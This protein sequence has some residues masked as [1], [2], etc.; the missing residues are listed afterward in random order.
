MSS[1]IARKRKTR[2]DDGIAGV[3]GDGAGG[4]VKTQDMM[5]EIMALI[6]Q[7]NLQLKAQMQN[8]MDTMRRLHER[9]IDEMKRHYE[10]EMN[11]IKEK[12]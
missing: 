7:N 6:E 10:H 1:D 5:T 2:P 12:M 9:E 11:K 3:A 4:E 8:E